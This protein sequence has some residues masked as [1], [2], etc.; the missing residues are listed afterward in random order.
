MANPISNLGTPPSI[1]VA[2]RV[3]TDFTNFKMLI[4][5]TSSQEITGFRLYNTARAAESSTTG[6]YAPSGVTF[7]LWAMRFQNITGTTNFEPQFGYGDTAT[8]F[9]T[10][11]AAPPTNAVYFGGLGAGGFLRFNAAAHTISEVSYPGLSVPSGKYPIVHL[12]TGGATRIVLYGYE[13]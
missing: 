12:D 10:D 11:T 2:G 13:V 7:V 4:G 9:D 8:A 1:T 5:L 3:F 6:I